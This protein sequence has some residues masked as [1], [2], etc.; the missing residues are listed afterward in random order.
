MI[1]CQKAFMPKIIY[2]KWH[3]SLPMHMYIGIGLV[4]SL[5]K[6]FLSFRLRGKEQQWPLPELSSYVR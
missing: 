2:A 4:V 6:V 5:G 1:L 3:P